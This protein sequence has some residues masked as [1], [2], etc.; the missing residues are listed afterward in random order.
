MTWA[1]CGEKTPAMGAL[2]RALPFMRLLGMVI[3]PHLRSPSC[4]VYA[5]PLNLLSSRLVRYGLNCYLIPGIGSYFFI[6]IYEVD[7]GVQKCYVHYKGEDNFIP[8]A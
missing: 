7:A 3:E 4:R 2:W 8:A 5:V 6:R 1:R